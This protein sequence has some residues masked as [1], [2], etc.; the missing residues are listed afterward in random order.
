MQQRT[1]TKQ[2]HIKESQIYRAI[3]YSIETV[4]FVKENLHVTQENSP[5]WTIAQ[6]SDQEVIVSGVFYTT[7]LE[8]LFCF[9][10]NSFEIHI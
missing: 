7:L 1:N 9:C 2:G 3:K 5:V 4:S 8:C 6:R 10:N